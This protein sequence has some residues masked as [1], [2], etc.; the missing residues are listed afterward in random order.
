M[1]LVK[2]PEADAPSRRATEIYCVRTVCGSPQKIPLIALVCI[3]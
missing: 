2:V 1:S 3:G